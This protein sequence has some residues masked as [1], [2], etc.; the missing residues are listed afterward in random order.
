MAAT[1]SGCGSSSKTEVS[2]PSNRGQ[3]IEQVTVRFASKGEFPVRQSV[4]DVEMLEMLSRDC[5][6][7]GPPA[8]AYYRPIVA[9]AREHMVDHDERRVHESLVGPNTPPPK[10][11][12]GTNVIVDPRGALGELRIVAVGPPFYAPGEQWAE[13]R[14]CLHVLKQGTVTTIAVEEIWRRIR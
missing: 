4:S 1:L 3:Q 11:H 12:D 10:L 2:E 9:F 14:Y 5:D 8:P 7:S 13:G 6:R